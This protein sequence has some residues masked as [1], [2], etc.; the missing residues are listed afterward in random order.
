MYAVNSVNPYLYLT[1]WSV[2]KKPGMEILLL[3]VT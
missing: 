2:S 1:M 3:Q